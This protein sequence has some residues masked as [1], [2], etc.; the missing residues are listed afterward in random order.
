MSYA[1]LKGMHLWVAPDRQ[2]HEVEV[3]CATSTA[4][5]GSGG[6]DAT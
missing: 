4:G 5:G 6:A 2:K 1:K 3:P